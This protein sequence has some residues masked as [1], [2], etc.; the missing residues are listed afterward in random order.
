MWRNI[1]IAILA[2]VV[3][4]IS[5]GQAYGTPPGAEFIPATCESRRSS[6][7]M[8][9][10]RGEVY[11]VVRTDVKGELLWQ[12]PDMSVAIHG[13]YEFFGPFQEP[14]EE[15]VLKL[16]KGDGVI[17]GNGESTLSGCRRDKPEGDSNRRV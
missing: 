12:G 4:C 5:S 16:V 9:A 1:Q 15:F 3:C 11:H 2:G 8:L 10:E 13:E 17:V 6:F 7:L 14:Q